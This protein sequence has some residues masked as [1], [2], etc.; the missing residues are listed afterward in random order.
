MI[1]MTSSPADPRAVTEYRIPATALRVGDLVNTAPGGPDDWQ[2]VLAVHTAKDA[3]A[4][5]TGLLRRIGDRYVVV[6]LSDIGPVD[7]DVFLQ[8]G[9]AYVYGTDGEDDQLVDDVISGADDRRTYLYTVYELVT[10]RPG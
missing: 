5:L 8:D 1:G 2:K 4:D 10:V 6:E 7:N 3:G 9:D